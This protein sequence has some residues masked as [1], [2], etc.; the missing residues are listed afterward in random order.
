MTREELTREEQI[1]LDALRSVSGSDREAV[2]DMLADIL[3]GN[4]E[5]HTRVVG[6]AAETARNRS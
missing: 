2:A 3:S 6:M 1:V 4:S 5:C